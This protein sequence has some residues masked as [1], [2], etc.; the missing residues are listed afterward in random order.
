MYETKQTTIPL[1]SRLNGYYCKEKKGSYRPQFSKAYYEASHINNS[2][3]RKEKDPGSFTLPCFINN[4]YFDNALA[5]LGASVIVMPLSTYLN[6][7]LGELAHTKLTV[8]FAD[9]TVKY[10]KGI[11]ENVLVEIG[12]FVFLMDFIILDMPEDIKVPLILERPFLSTAHAKIDVFKRKIMLRVGEE[13]IIFKSVKPASSLIKRVYMLGLRERIELDLEARLMG[14]TLVLNR[15]LD[16]FFEDYIELNDLN[17]PL[18]LRRDQVDNL[19]PT[20]EEGEVAEEFRARNDTRMVIKVFGYPSDCDY[21]KKIYIDCAYNLKFS[22]MIVL[23]DMDSYR[24]EEMGDVI[25]GEPFLREVGIK[26]R[27]FEGMITIDN[28]NEEVTYQMVRS[29]LRFKHHTNGQCNKIPPLLKVSEEDKMNGIS[30]SYQKLK[31]FYKGVLNLGP[32]YV[33]DAK[34]EEWLTRGHISNE[35]FSTW[36]AFGGNTRDLDSFGEETDKITDLHQ[37]LEEVLLT[38]HGDGVTAIKRRRRDPSSDGV[39]DL[40]MASGRSR[41]NED[42]ESST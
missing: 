39:R 31:N 24:D 41:L 5:D 8:E 40:V 4:V 42:L 36:M 17:V 15:S 13:K 11:A 9:R 21:D 7:R 18:E 38:E 10:P 16:P 27:R 14:E 3:P 25:L 30:H 20:I 2:M 35:V 37:I 6:L 1:P 32:E 19:I 29:H 22:C 28:G 12:K 23:E 26:A 34:M 33:R